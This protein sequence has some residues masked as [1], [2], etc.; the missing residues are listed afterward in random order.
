[1]SM[2]IYL[3]DIFH[4][5]PNELENSKFEVNMVDG[6]TQKEQLPRWLELPD[7]DKIAGRN[8]ISYW[9]WYGKQRNFSEGQWVFSF[10]RLNRIDEWLLISAA[11]IVKITDGHAQVDILERFSP[12][13]GRLIVNWSKGS[14][15]SRWTFNLAR[16]IN[17]ITVKEV[18]PN[19]YS[20]ADKAF[21]GYDTVHLSFTELED[22][23]QKRA[24]FAYAVA[25]EKISGIYCL[26]DTHNGKLYIGSATGEGGLAQRWGNYLDSKHGGNKELIELYKTKGESYFRENITFTLL[27]WFNLSY[28][29]DK[30]LARENYWKDCLDTRNGHGYNAN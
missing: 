12:Y 15:F 10:I 19:L 11:K 25:L 27:E 29:P 5:T 2:V 28:D 3:N 30:I 9:T 14:K 17:E 21:E 4:L 18:L 23:L 20:V 1:M 26:T 16:Y 24:Y 13:F 8:P 22:I 6:G 7:E